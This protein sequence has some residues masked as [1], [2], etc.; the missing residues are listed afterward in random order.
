[1]LMKTAERATFQGGSVVWKKAKDA[2]SLDIKALLQHQP[3][4]IE[5]YPL[6]KQGSRRFNIY[7]DGI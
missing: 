2:I 3:E 7:S 6:H 5:Q 1:M 4:L